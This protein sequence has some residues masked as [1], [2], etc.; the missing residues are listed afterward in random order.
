MLMGLQDSHCIVPQAVWSSLGNAAQPTWAHAGGGVGGPI[1][2]H[3][4]P[5][6]EWWVELIHSITHLLNL[7]LLIS[8]RPYQSHGCHQLFC[9]PT[10]CASVWVREPCDYQP[11]SI[12]ADTLPMLEQWSLTICHH[13]LQEQWPAPQSPTPSLCHVATLT[14]TVTKTSPCSY[15]CT[16]AD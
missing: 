7:Y 9:C 4:F 2:I 6:H 5:R 1:H 13:P 10:L 14:V 12:I 3:M 16:T 8:I 15:P 11:A